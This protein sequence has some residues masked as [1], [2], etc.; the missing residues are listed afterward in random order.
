MTP[1]EPMALSFLDK[2]VDVAVFLVLAGC[3]GCM[4]YSMGFFALVMCR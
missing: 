2:T 3:L 1:R 4:L